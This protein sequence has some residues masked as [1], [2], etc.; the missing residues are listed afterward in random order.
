MDLHIRRSTVNFC[1]LAMLEGAGFSQLGAH[2][3]RF[4]NSWMVELQRS[5]GVRPGELIGWR[6]S[7]KVH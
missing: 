4:R 2:A 3:N 5:G 6:R 1:Q 7:L